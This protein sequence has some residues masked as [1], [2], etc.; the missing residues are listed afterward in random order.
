MD[1]HGNEEAF[2]VRI[3]EDASEC[4]GAKH[5]IVL[6][7]SWKRGGL[8]DN[9]RNA[10]QKTNSPSLCR[11][12]WATMRSWWKSSV[13]IASPWDLR[14]PERHIG[15][16]LSRQA[17]K[18]LFPSSRIPIWLQSKK[19]EVRQASKSRSCQML[20]HSMGQ[21]CN[22]FRHQ[23]ADGAAACHERR[24]A[25]LL[26]VALMRALAQE[27]AVALAERVNLAVGDPAA[28][29]EDEHAGQRPIFHPCFKIY[30]G[31]LRLRLRRLRWSS[32][33]V[34]AM[35]FQPRRTMP[36]GNSYKP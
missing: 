10:F 32:R 16:G 4:H 12:D 1:V 36:A 35:V 17:V 7:K 21:A 3:V 23:S 31:V 11:M 19:R 5:A 27:T 13:R 24:A 8:H 26:P 14:Q 9:W 2:P 34:D 20:I 15:P 18:V 29:V 6:V 25:N 22:Q 28:L 33:W 30:E